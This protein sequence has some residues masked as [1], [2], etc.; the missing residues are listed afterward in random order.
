MDSGMLVWQPC[1]PSKKDGDSLTFKTQGKKEK[2]VMETGLITEANM[3]G[4]IW[5]IVLTKKSHQVLYIL[6]GLNIQIST[7]NSL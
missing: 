4:K 3:F 1:A 2:L 5:L 6:L 7:A